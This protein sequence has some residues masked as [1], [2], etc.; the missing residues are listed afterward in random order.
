MSDFSDYDPFY[1][2]GVFDACNGKPALYNRDE[3]DIAVCAYFDG[4]DGNDA[5]INE[6]TEEELA[7]RAYEAGAKY[8]KED[9]EARRHAAMAHG[10]YSDQWWDGF[11]DNA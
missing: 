11:Y 1:R 2:S 10:D 9:M 3:N 5:K 4:Y 6:P 7:E 8:A